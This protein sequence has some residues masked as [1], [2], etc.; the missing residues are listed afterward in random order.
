MAERVYLDTNAFRYFGEAFKT[1]TLPFNLRERVLMS[2]LSAFEVM[3]QLADAYGDVVMRQIQCIRNWT[4]SHHAGLL[5][6]SQ[7][8]MHSIWFQKPVQDDGTTKRMQDSINVIL[9]TDSLKD[10]QE[11]AGK[12]KQ[13]M[14]DLKLQAAQSFKT[15]IGYAR[16]NK[17]DMTDAWFRGIA[18]SV[19]ADPKSRS[20][21]EIKS[22]LSAYHEYEQAKLKVALDEPEYNPL[23][24]TNQNDIIDAEQLVYL[25]DPT[26]CFLT[27]DKK[28][29]NRVKA[30]VQA[31]RIIWA[32]AEDL[33]DPARA[34][35]LLRKIVAD[36]LTRKV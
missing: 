4:N 14:V 8:V 33:Q 21:D 13:F 31:S 16:S 7:D 34:T 22:A 23:S 2:P 30:S 32:S 9:N 19:G 5:P 17:F 35:A 15:M 6:P 25:W 18:N 26:L 20:V 29:K 11:E 3:K 10:I 36:Q 28:V 27:A 1:A 24:L 12:H